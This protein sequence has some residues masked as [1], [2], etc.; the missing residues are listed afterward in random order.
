MRSYPRRAFTVDDGLL[1][2]SE[3]DLT[4]KQEALFLVSSISE[5]LKPQAM[6]SDGSV[7]LN[8]LI[9]AS[10]ISDVAPLMSLVTLLIGGNVSNNL[11]Y[12]SNPVKQ[13]KVTCIQ[14]D[15]I[16]PVYVILTS[17]CHMPYRETTS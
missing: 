12:T 11:L 7:Y 4:N 6:P 17:T 3:L 2:L 8:W 13:T 10:L 14:Q 9:A 16:M 1:T 15:K 5:R